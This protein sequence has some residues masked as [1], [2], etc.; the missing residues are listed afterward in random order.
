[1]MLQEAVGLGVS[2]VAEVQLALVAVPLAVATLLGPSLVPAIPTP[3][4]WSRRGCR[5]LLTF[6]GK[7]KKGEC[8]WRSVVSVVALLGVVVPNQTFCQFQSVLLQWR[9]T[10]N[11]R[12]LLSQD[13]GVGKCC[14]EN[15]P[16]YIS[17]ELP[18]FCSYSVVRPQ[19]VIPIYSPHELLVLQHSLWAGHVHLPPI[20]L[21][22]LYSSDLRWLR[23][24]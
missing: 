7:V 14:L 11:T 15:E 21:T 9:S 1:M 19:L 6:H 4:A 18:T 24:G 5:C 16:K 22:T 20:R 23:V 17:I 10:C 12:V 3:T 2:G 8:G 13:V